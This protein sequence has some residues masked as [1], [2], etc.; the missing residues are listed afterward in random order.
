M[1]RKKRKNLTMDILRAVKARRRT[2]EIQAFGHTIL[3]ARVQKNK[4]IYD[5]KKN[6]AR[7]FRDPED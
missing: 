2:E 6:A 5:R 1:N 4:K 7:R 3:H